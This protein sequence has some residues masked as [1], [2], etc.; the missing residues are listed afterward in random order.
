MPQHLVA[1][2]K[3]KRSLGWTY[4]LILASQRG[5]KYLWLP[6]GTETLGS[7]FY[8]E[9]I[10]AGKCH[11]GVLLLDYYDQDQLN[12]PGGWPKS[13]NPTLPLKNLASWEASLTHQWAGSMSSLSQASTAKQPWEPAPPNSG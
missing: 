3:S 8:P 2:Q 10:G 13:Q 1:R 6:L 9:N 12:L 11:F 5:R 4:L 7:L